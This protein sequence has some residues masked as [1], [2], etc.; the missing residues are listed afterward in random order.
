MKKIILLI[1]AMFAF[2]F[3]AQ[4][5]VSSNAI[6]L[7]LGGGS[8]YGGEISYQKGLG[9]AHRL[10]LDLGFGQNSNHNRFYLAAIYHWNWNITGVLNW[11]IGPG[12]SVGFYSY[13]DNDGYVNVALGG[14]V[15]IE[16]N[17]NVHSVPLLLSIDA[18]PMWD[19]LGD[20]S[21]LGWGA[22]LGVRYLF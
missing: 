2:G 9:D 12:A 6:G 13:N 22:A 16:Y 18:R 17:F 7:R 3:L 4:S 5:Q 11:Y 10:E 14:Q 21:G 1:T 8:V 20:N 19:F 15:G